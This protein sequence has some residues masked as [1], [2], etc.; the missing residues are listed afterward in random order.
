MEETKLLRALVLLLLINKLAV[1]ELKALPPIHSTNKCQNILKNSRSCFQDGSHFES[2]VLEL[3]EESSKKVENLLDNSEF[4]EFVA[5]L[6]E[7]LPEIQ[8]SKTLQQKGELLIFVSFSLGEKALLNLASEAKKYGGMLVLRGFKERSFKKT[9][10]AL[11]KII[12]KT[13][14]GLIVDPEL[15]NLFNVMSVPTYILSNPVH[16]NASTRTSTPFHDRL[17]GDMSLRFALERI[18]KDGD[19]REVAQTFLERGKP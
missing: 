8:R 3:Q 16:M 7:K 10:Q 1:F 6:Q 15:Y 11:Q 13:G 18:V 5:K 9:A 4:V 2:E 12:T 17:Q 19:L 14:Y